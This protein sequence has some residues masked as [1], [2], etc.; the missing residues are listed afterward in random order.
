MKNILKVFKR[1]L[2]SIIKN[3]A[4]ILIVVGLSFIPSLYAWINIKAC[5]NPYENT[6]TLPVAIVN[7]DEGYEINGKSINIGNQVMCELKKNKEIGWK[8][9]NSKVGNIGIV[10]GTYYALIEIPEDFSKDLSSLISDRP[11]K[12]EIT[13]KVNTKIN[14]V[15]GKIT[16][17]AESSLI[18]E[19][20]SNFI[21]TVSKEAFS[22][23]NG[24]GSNV[25]KNKEEIIQLKDSIINVNMNMNLITGLLQN[26]SSNS[27]NLSS[28]LTEVKGTLPQVISNID[29]IQSSTQGTENFVESTK[30]TLNN[31]YN[32]LN[33][34]LKQSQFRIDKVKN[35]LENL[36]TNSSS[37]ATIETSR[38]IISCEREFDIIMTGINNNIRFLEEINKIKSNNKISNLIEKL[39]G[40][41]TSLN[42]DKDSLN[43]L[44]QSVDSEER[45]NAN[46]INSALA[47]ISNTSNSINKSINEYTSNVMPELNKISNNLIGATQD[48][49]SLLDS[50]KGLVKEVGSLLTSATDGCNLASE[51]SNNLNNKLNEFREIISNLSGKLEKV[52]N[53]QLTQI[54]SILQSRP[55]IMANF[56]SSP[57]NL[58]DESIYPIPNYGSGMAPIYSVLALWVGALILTSILRIDPIDF[59]GS[60]SI[61]LIQK[62]FGKMLTFI[63]ISVIQ[64]L[65]VS[66]GDKFLL[67]I[68]TV[69]TPLL[70][71]FAVVSSITFCIITYTLAAL[72][73]N[74]GKAI[75][76]ILMVIQLAG[77][78]G[79][80]PIQV[81]P[82]FFRVVQPFLPFTYSVGGFREAIAGPLMSSVSLDFIVLFIFSL[83]F[84]IMGVTLKKPLYGI[85][86]KFDK[87]FEKS[88][89]AE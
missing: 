17:V 12:P 60:E 34:N 46:A 69:S 81:D 73:G 86:R 29:G 48:A 14:P 75:G 13:Y 35:S 61:T 26:I 85:M 38:I 74:I 44:Q 4:A 71:I 57:F 31:S 82:T 88:G 39:R 89:V 43:K 54:I 40:I 20:T 58:K 53:D 67:H 3:P 42:K 1:D 24:F 79:T 51:T 41:E 37:I 22:Y 9:V 6:S 5:W 62:Y 70:I 56:M 25:E 84:I 77:S 65:I 55:E 45:L 23:L 18:N 33:E 83:I 66:L 21:D 19:I 63:L 87:K 10:D 30:K 72:F 15:S 64:G 49:V 11:I 52:N 36:K 50:S 78:G 47:D 27:T 7:N 32:N 16:E 28:Y 76:I 8:F 68:Y 59:K 80:Y 2:K